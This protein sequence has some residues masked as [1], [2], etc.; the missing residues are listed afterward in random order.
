MIRRI[1]KMLRLEAEAITP[2]VHVPVLSRDRAIEKIP[3]VELHARL[4]R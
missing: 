3:R 4:G 2:L 1:R